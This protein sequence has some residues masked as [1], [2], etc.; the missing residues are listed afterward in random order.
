MMY[1]LL[2]LAWNSVLEAHQWLYNKYCEKCYPLRMR[3]HSLRIRIRLAARG[4]IVLTDQD[5]QK[6]HRG[7]EQ[8]IT[9][10]M[11]H[12][13]LSFIAE[14]G[15]FCRDDLDSDIM[16]DSLNGLLKAMES[17]EKI[18]GREVRK[19]FPVGCS[20]KEAKHNL[21]NLFITKMN[22]TPK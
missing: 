22:R 7:A 13:H 2:K 16:A 9:V 3:W 6:V 8:I 19:C 1:I 12:R 14:L 20:M 21:Q 18:Y 11:L 17:K 15:R 4:N 10:L 5:A